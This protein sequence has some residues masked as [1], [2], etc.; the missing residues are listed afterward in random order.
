[1]SL[2]DLCEREV[3]GSGSKATYDSMAG[4]GGGEGGGVYIKNTI[5]NKGN[6]FDTI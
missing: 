1:M 6:Q 4:E 2:L 5:R 3:Y